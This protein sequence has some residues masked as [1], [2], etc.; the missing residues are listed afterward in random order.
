MDIREWM[1]PSAKRR[2]LL[3]YITCAWLLLIAGAPAAL[4]T[5]R[6]PAVFSSG[7]VLQAGKPVKIWGQATPGDV[8]TVNLLTERQSAVADDEGTWEVTFPPQASGVAGG[9]SVR[10]RQSELIVRDVVF[11]EVWVFAGSDGLSAD[12]SQ[13]PVGARTLAS[14][15]LPQLRFFDVR[16]RASDSPLGPSELEGEWR[17]ALPRELANESALAY[18][19]GR[20]LNLWEAVP[21]G[22]IVAEWDETPVAAWTPLDALEDISEGAPLVK[23]YRES[24]AIYQAKVAEYAARAKAWQSLSVYQDP[25]NR[26]YWRGL[27]KPEHDD[28]RWKPIQVPGR[29]E[30]RGL[31][32]DGAVW[33]R[34]KVEIPPQW[35]GQTLELSL[36]EVLNSDE[37]YFEG[38][39]VG[40]SRSLPNVKLR[41]YRLDSSLVREGVATIAVR[42][43]NHSGDGGLVGP[44]NVMRLSLL[45]APDEGVIPLSGEWLALP[46]VPFPEDREILDEAKPEIPKGL[47]LAQS[48][49]NLFNGMIEPLIPLSIRG[50][51]FSGGL[52]DIR[53]PEQYGG[54][55][56]QM[57]DS[58]R[59]RWSP[60]DL[61]FVF[62]QSPAAG[63]SRL[64]LLE[65]GSRL[66]VL[67][68]SQQL[69]LR[70]PKTAM[71]VALD[72]DADANPPSWL[73]QLAARLALE[74]RSSVYNRSELNG[75][76]PVAVRATRNGLQVKIELA[77]AAAG[78]GTSDGQL[79]RGVVLRG[80]DG[81]WQA[82]NVNL[83]GDHLLVWNETMLEPV[84]VRYGWA[85]NPA[86]N[87]FSR[88]GQPLA[89]FRF[90]VEV[91]E[92]SEVASNTLPVLH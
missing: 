69:A 52:T 30:D 68:E 81:T 80:A 63:S 61:P 90:Q 34:K 4:A 48:P 37:V 47:N 91:S 72:F 75:Q 86:I 43:F 50:F 54:I 21:V 56:V 1:P 46:T 79:P 49:A 27:A 92:D 35:V 41:R 9:M 17:A 28:S 74:V 70:L 53:R 19:F 85:D 51:V 55:F 36:G 11:G 22:I 7:A 33:L 18:F 16:R 39:P 8:V 2:P 26:G 25:G 59:R 58:W 76:S 24:L 15:N 14:H 67:R 77:N 23:E 71:V 10:S 45:N 3:I 66:A 65:E 31:P 12:L 88:S 89:P 57:L 87:I 62:V 29:W 13:M 44:A 84:E 5:L 20:E 78:L 42:V 64:N 40:S 83:V 82:A 6:L 38:T 60:E 73:P 32:I